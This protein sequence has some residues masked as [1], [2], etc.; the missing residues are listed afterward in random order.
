MNTS[1]VTWKKLVTVAV[2]FAASL[3][4]Q[5]LTFYFPVNSGVM[6]GYAQYDPST[7]PYGVSNGPTG[8]ATSLDTVFGPPYQ[9][10]IV[11][12][13]TGYGAGSY[14][15]G[16]IYGPNGFEDVYVELH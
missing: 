12:D 15:V 8:P 1:S 9:V 13:T 14:Y 3:C 16:T 11:V 4:A 2:F 5:A 10:T 6:S 7:A